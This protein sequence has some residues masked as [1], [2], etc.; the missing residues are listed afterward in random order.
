MK[1][2]VMFFA[3]YREALGVDS[4][5]WRATSPLDDVRQAWWP[6]AG[7]RSAGRAEPDVRAQRRTVQLDEP[8]RRATK[9]RF[10]RRDRRLTMAVCRR[11]RSIRGRSQRHARGQCRRGRGG[12]FCRLRARLQRRPRR[13]GDVPRA[14]S[15]HDRKALAKIAVEAEQRWP[16]LKLEVLHRI[17][18][19][20][21]GEPIVFVGGRQRAPSGGVRRLCFVMDYLKTRAPFWKKEHTSDGRAGS[22]GASRAIRRGP[23]LVSVLL[24]FGAAIRAFAPTLTETQTHCVEPARDGVGP[25]PLLRIRLLSD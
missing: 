23:A 7:V 2:K 22:K 4:S 1:V 9:S 20:E 10:S 21:P 15:G 14:L 11:R 17:G 16:L 18:A 25:P 8:L 12:R 6:R 19:L 13:G 5:G 24:R 3:R